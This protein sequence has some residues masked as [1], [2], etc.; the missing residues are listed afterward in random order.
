MTLIEPDWPAPAQVRACATTRL[1]GVSTGP[2]RSL[3]LAQH[4]EDDPRAVIENRRR[5]K[6]A[7]DLLHEPIWL[8]QVHGIDIV[9]AADQARGAKADACVSWA[10]GLACVVMTADCLPVLF[11]DR[12]G[13]VV[14]AAHAGWRGLAHGVLEATVRKLAKPASELLAWLGP[15]IEQE[16]FEVGDEVRAAFEHLSPLRERSTKSGE[17]ETAFRRNARGRWQADLYALAKIE[18]GALGVN[19]IYGGGERCYADSDRFFS[20]RR[21]GRTGRMATLIWLA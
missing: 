18:L 10:P 11:C 21:D 2:F 16:A 20:F 17:G 1:G 4:V 5:L 13:T 3:N 14:G 7:A 15:A 9:E 12:A 8:E 6:A 19:E